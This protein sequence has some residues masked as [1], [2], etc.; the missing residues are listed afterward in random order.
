ML[1]RYIIQALRLDPPHR[2]FSLNLAKEKP[3][4]DGSWTSKVQNALK[5]LLDIC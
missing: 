4:S 3:L 5:D 2:K 1:N